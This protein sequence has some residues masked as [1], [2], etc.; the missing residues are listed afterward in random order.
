MKLKKCQK[1]EN[2]IKMFNFLVAC[3]NGHS[4]LF[5]EIKKMRKTKKTCPNTMDGISDNIPGHFKS[6]YKDF[7]NCVKDAVEIGAIQA[8]VE[9]KVPAEAIKDV[10]KVTPEEVKEAAAALKP[11]KG[12]P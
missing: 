11:G 4:D 2:I 8:K 6:I 10:M 1:S 9:E 12:D 7:Y 3:L 5:K